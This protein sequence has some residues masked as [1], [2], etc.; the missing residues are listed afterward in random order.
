MDANLEYDDIAPGISDDEHRIGFGRI[1]QIAVGVLLVVAG[2]ALLVLPGQGVITVIVGLNLIKP[3]NFMVRWL[4]R[5]VP[6]IP[7]EGA[8][9]MRYVVVGGVFFVATTI[10]S[11]LYGDDLLAWFLDQI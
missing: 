10:L 1:L 9:P 5:K 8:I 6:G 11:L 7:E 4:R 2:L 3:D